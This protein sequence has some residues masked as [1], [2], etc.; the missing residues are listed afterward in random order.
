MSDEKQPC[1]AWK[2]AFQAEETVPTKSVRQ[3]QA[4]HV[5]GKQ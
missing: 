2:G 4:R 1:E 5:Q 3:E